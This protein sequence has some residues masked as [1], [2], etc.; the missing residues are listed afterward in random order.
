MLPG[1]AEES[2]KEITEGVPGQE[3]RHVAG[4]E[5]DVVPRQSTLGPHPRVG[6]GSSAWLF[7][8]SDG[9]AGRVRGPGGHCCA[10]KS[11]SVSPSLSS[12]SS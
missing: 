5:G 7:Q 8:G 2:A 3:V 1:G 9:P 10:G 11:L 4:A 12:V 6:D